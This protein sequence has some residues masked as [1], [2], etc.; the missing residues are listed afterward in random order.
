MKNS[1]EMGRNQLPTPLMSEGSILRSLER[2][3]RV[4]VQ[5]I[6]KEPLQPHGTIAG[7]LCNQRGTSSQE[8]R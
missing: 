1:S 5:N 6:I 3:R 8:P 2:E 4:E 7:A